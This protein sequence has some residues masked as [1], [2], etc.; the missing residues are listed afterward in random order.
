MVSLPWKR[1][2]LAIVLGLFD[3]RSE[4]NIK[5]SFEEEDLTCEQNQM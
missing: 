2:V 3:L 4:T 1:V 5:T